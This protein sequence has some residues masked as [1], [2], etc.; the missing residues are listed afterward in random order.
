MPGW[1]GIVYSANGSWTKDYALGII[2]FVGENP[3]EEKSWRKREAP[4]LISDGRNAGPFGPG[5]ASFVSGEC[6][7]KGGEMVMC[8]YHG[9]EREDEGWNNRKERVL[10]LGQECF[11]EDAR[12]ICCANMRNS[13]MNEQVD[14]S[15][16]HQ[17]GQHG[18]KKL[19]ARGSIE[20]EV[21][22]VVR[23]IF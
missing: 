4:L 5:H 23:Y 2:E 10:C 18:L 3:C 21:E 20:A 15:S 1:R 13:S 7:G 19:G 11:H 8:V 17:G 14:G 16:S 22:R 12:P 9:T 6:V